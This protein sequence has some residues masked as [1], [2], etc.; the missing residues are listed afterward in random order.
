MEKEEN[1]NQENTTT[2]TSNEKLRLIN[3]QTIN[4]K[5]TKFQKKKLNYLLK[6]R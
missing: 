6:K 3:N 1:L 2:E 4:K 5:R